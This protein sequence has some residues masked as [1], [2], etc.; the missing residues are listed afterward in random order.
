[1][2]KMRRGIT[3]VWTS[4]P[5]G[6]R[7]GRHDAEESRRRCRGV[8]E[9]TASRSRGGRDAEESWRTADTVAL[10]LVPDRCPETTTTT[11]SR[12]DVWL[13]AVLTEGD[14]R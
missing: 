13:S 9:D 4:S 1:M 11:M 2:N 10:F 3:K 8:M 14:E 5:G 12:R 7:R 6:D